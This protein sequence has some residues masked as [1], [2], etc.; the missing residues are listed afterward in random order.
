MR[1][2]NNSIVR[3]FFD[4]WH[5]HESLVRCKFYTVEVGKDLLMVQHRSN[6]ECCGLTHFFHIMLVMASRGSNQ[7]NVDW[8]ALFRKETS[9]HIFKSIATMENE[10]FGEFRLRLGPEVAIS[11]YWHLKFFLSRAMRERES[12]G[13]LV[14]II[15]STFNEDAEKSL[16]YMRDLMQLSEFPFQHTNKDINEVG[17]NN[18]NEGKVE[19]SRKA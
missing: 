17:T 16:A 9:E 10:I 6:Q 14:K 19:S 13:D 18:A 12:F 4:C 5:Y 3:D 8:E 7:N 15:V 11:N 2:D 1:K